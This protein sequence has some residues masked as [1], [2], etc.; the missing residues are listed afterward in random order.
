MLHISNR[1]A[2]SSYEVDLDVT[3][4]LHDTRLR[5]RR[6]PATCSGDGGSGGSGGRKPS[7]KAMQRK[8]VKRGGGKEDRNPNNQANVHVHCTQSYPQ[9]S[10]HHHKAGNF[11]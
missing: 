10:I 11:Y 5:R 7:P 3:K 1:M 4:S 9:H 8:R 2:A 6:S